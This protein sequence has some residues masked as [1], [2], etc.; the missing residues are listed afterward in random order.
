MDH[1]LNE[2]ACGLS[3]ALADTATL[4]EGTLQ[5]LD[6][7]A[8]RYDGDARHLAIRALVAR[9]RDEV[10][11]AADTSEAIATALQS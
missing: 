4:A 6:D 1:K 2:T 10:A 9:I 5:L 8:G 3:H 7:T 11:Q